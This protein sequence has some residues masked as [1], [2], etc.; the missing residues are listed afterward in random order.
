M[1]LPVPPER[2][3][4]IVLCV[5]V[6]AA[7]NLVGTWRAEAIDPT[8]QDSMILA[9]LLLATAISGKDPSATLRL[10]GRFTA[11][12]ACPIG[13]NEALTS[14]HVIDLRPFDKDVPLYPYRY[15]TADLAQVGIVRPRFVHGASDLGHIVPQG[16]PFERFYE[17]AQAAPKTGDRVSFHGYDFRSSGKAW[18]ER[19]YEAKVRRIVAGNI[20]LD[21]EPDRGTSGS[22][23]FDADG[24]VLA[25]IC[26]GVAYVGVA[27]GVWSPWL[28]ENDPVMVSVPS[29]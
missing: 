25:V 5:A 18:A 8:G 7:A 1:K 4:L 21:K 28:E 29:R 16:L 11:A 17:I 3:P 23:V 14:A 15:S 2:L 24:R 20:V 9:P 10:I 19:N 12:Q 13:P 6:I 27:V 26:W 22:C